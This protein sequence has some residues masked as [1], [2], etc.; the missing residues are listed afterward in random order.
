MIL[1]KKDVLCRSSIRSLKVQIK[2]R[3]VSCLFSSII[4]FTSTFFLD[5][6]VNI[7]EDRRHKYLLGQPLTKNSIIALLGWVGRSVSV[8]ILNFIAIRV[9]KFRIPPVKPAHNCKTFRNRTSSQDPLNFPVVAADMHPLK[10][11]LPLGL[12]RSF[13]H[14]RRLRYWLK[15]S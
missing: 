4:I 8:R 6:T 5:K 14:K 12:A 15:L 9:V 1:Q 11:I 3:S 2:F 10:H 13:S 7:N